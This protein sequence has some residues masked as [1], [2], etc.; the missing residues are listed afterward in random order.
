MRVLITDAQGPAAV[1]AVRSLGR[2]GIEAEAGCSAG[3]F[4]LAAY[5]RHCAGRVELPDPGAEPDRYADRIV[6][7]ARRAEI[8][9]VLP[10]SDQTFVACAPARA[11]IERHAVYCAAAPRA[12]EAAW[13]KWGIL[14]RGRQAGL[15]VPAARRVREPGD[16][17]HAREEV[18]LPV[19]HRARW[20]VT[21]K[22]DRLVKP[23][24]AVFFEAA[25]ADRDAR[26]RLARGEEFVASRWSRGTG[27]G[28]Y[29]FVVDRRAVLWF[30]HRRLRETNPCG[31]PACAALAE[32]PDAESVRRCAALLAGL[33]VEGAA[34]VEFRRDEE[35]ER[36]L[37]V[38]INPRLWG[39]VPLA[40]GSGIDF[41]AHHVLFFI[42]GR[43]PEMPGR[44]APV[45][46]YRYLTAD[47][48][49]VMHA[50]KGPPPAWGGDYPSFRDARQGF[51][52]SFRDGFG[53]YHQSRDDPLPGI[54]EPFAYLVGRLR[55][56][57]R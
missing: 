42:T 49:H 25:A 54:L 57:R 35:G 20:S 36:D 52:Q 31:A 22:V 55:R 28:V 48:V 46:G 30:G 24:A 2:L 5:S 3:A 37:L 12:L 10:L 43:V 38:E 40:V 50:W 6:E 23:P 21:R 45:A 41:P 47:L 7:Q 26:A 14:E 8:D 15:A 13:D 4:P 29:L 33:G 44:L 11:E 32:Q 18:G 39:S 51:V 9:A 19:V 16:L 1:A 53:Y 27:R 34:M 56:K 17:E